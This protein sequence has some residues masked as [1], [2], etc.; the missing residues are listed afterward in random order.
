MDTRYTVEKNVQILISL[1]KQNGIRKII[2]SPGTTNITFVASLQSDPFFEM[3]SAADERSAAYM[4]CGLAEES[5]EPVVITCTGATASRNYVPGLTEAYYRKLPV[6]AVTSMTGRS[7]VGNLNPQ[8]IDRSRI[9]NDIAV[10]S[11]PVPFIHDS[12]DERQC[13]LTV[14]KAIMAL[15]ADGGGPVHLDVET[16]ISTD[17]SVTDLPAVR[18]IA[19]YGAEDA[20]PEIPVGRNVAVF[21]GSHRPWKEEEMKALDDFCGKYDAVVFCDLTSNYPGRFSARAAA[22]F[23]QRY[24]HTSLL[25]PD[26]LVH[27]GEVSGDYYTWKSLKPRSVWRVSPDGGLKDAF[28]CLDKVF[29]MSERFFFS[30]YAALRQESLRSGKVEEME[31]EYKSVMTSLPDLPFSNLWVAERLAGRIPSGSVV[32]LGILNSLRSWNFFRLD[33]SIKV[34]SNVGGFGIDGGLSSLVGSSL[35][36]PDVLHFGVFGDLAFF[37]DMNSLGNRHVRGNIRILLI[38]NGKGTEFRNYSHPA[39]MWGDEADAF[40]AAGGHYGNKSHELVSHYA[41]DLGFEY[42]AASGKDEFTKMS[43]RFISP[44]ISRPVLMEVFTDSKD[45]SDALEMFCGAVRP[46]SKDKAK[47]LIK[48]V[49]G[50]DAIEKVNKL[51]GR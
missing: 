9:Q 31:N 11:A 48:G 21:I 8:V 14:N 30:H 50:K 7:N 28:G 29:R 17:F 32:H 1:L 41:Q 37:Y 22:V 12:E 20:L 51:I 43:D 49:F 46:D 13:I 27:I 40:I 47:D 38:N 19:R 24:I 16:R 36:S 34:F 35:A 4:A 42:F 18:N 3:Y 25:K 2:A 6:L 33:P 44:D 5:G 15:G 39:S 10:F 26:I 23:S 45:E